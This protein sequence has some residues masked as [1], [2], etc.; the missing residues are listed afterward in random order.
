MI[1]PFNLTTNYTTGFL[2]DTFGSEPTFMMPYNP[3]YYL[4]LMEACGLRKAK[5]LWEWSV[6]L[7]GGVPP[8]LARLT[9]RL[10]RTTDVRVRE[11]DASRWYAESET[12][13]DLYNRAWQDNWAFMPQ[14]ADEFA[15]VAKDLKPLLSH[16]VV[17]LAEAPEGPLGFLL[18]LPDLNPRM[19][20]L[21]G[22]LLSRHTPS[23][24]WSMLTGRG[25]E[26]CR[27]ALLGV[28]PEGQ[29]AGIA[30][31]LLGHA[32]RSPAAAGWRR[33]TMGWTDP[34]NVD[35]SR[36]IEAVGG[37]QSKSFA[38]FDTVLEPR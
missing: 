6:P 19:R 25:I 20:P 30:A 26:S 23:L 24:V 15:Y 13:R 36:T 14:R 11:A 5:E 1:G 29:R 9:A 8:R 34:E 38:V 16:S 33:A 17:V 3:P 22:S 37:R 35:I 28:V 7:D 10:A 4:D 18:A 32:F 31:L 21:H 27:V 2:A 12:I